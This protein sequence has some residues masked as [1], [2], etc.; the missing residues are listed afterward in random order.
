MK[1]KEYVKKYGIMKGAAMYRAEKGGTLTPEIVKATDK[2]AMK[3]VSPIPSA[4]KEELDP[5]SGAI[6][7]GPETWEAGQGERVILERGQAISELTQH[8]GWR[9]WL[10]PQIEK[11]ISDFVRV[12]FHS[13]GEKSHQAVG[14]GNYAKRVLGHVTRWLQQFTTLAERKLRER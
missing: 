6:L 7:R 9:L 10:K 12:V 2:L 4:P 1:Y 11:D 3:V 5:L 14:G 8:P 13:E